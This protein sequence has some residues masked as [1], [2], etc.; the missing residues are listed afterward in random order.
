MKK[1]GTFCARYVIDPFPVTEHLLC[2]FA[3]Y[4]ANAGLSPQTVKSYLAAVRNAQLSLGLPYPREQ[5]SLPIFKRV[6]AGISRCKLRRGQPSKV[7]LPI[8]AQLLLKIKWSLE[9]SGHA[10]RLALWAVC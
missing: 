2:C 4:M 9:R 6:Q 5:S 8:T 3:A 10:D 1:F 7:R